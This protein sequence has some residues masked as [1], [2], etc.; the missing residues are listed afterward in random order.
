MLKRTQ[1]RKTAN[2]ANKAGQQS[3][4][5]NAF[6]LPAGL[7]CPGMTDVCGSICYA[8]KL[9]KIYPAFRKVVVSNLEQ[10]RDADIDTML[11]LI[12]DMVN[13]FRI[14]CDR[15][16]A[17]KAFRIHADGD[18]FSISY[19]R[20]WAAVIKANPDIQFW[21]YTRSFTENLNVIP[22]LANISNLSLYLSVDNDNRHLVASVISAYPVVR[23]ATL[24]DTYAEGADL[25]A[26]WANRPG[27]ICPENAKR[28][29]LITTNGGACINCD[30]CVSSK[31]NVRFAIKKR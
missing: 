4:I 24:T 12:S 23:I 1:D 29:P 14:D 17:T 27:A 25:M 20:V 8:G 5:A 22:I 16:G 2:L 30:L 9:E 19:A 10:L 18:F 7:S 26:E 31:A 3:V 13:D 28:I 11:R 21:A 15:R 6:S